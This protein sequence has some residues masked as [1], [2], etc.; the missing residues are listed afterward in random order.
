MQKTNLTRELK[1]D[2]KGIDKF[3]D[4]CVHFKLL[5]PEEFLGY[6]QGSQTLLKSATSEIPVSESDS[7]ALVAIYNATNGPGW[8]RSYNWLTDSVKNWYGVT[9][10][11]GR[12]TRLMMWNNNLQ[13]TLPA[14]ICNLTALN[15]LMIGYESYLTGTIPDSIGNLTELENL[16]FY[17]NGMTGAIPSSI[18][19]LQKLKVLYLVG[20][21]EMGAFSG[22]LPAEIGNLDSLTYLSIGNN[23]LEGVI[24]TEIGQ[25]AKL[26]YLNLNNN[27]L[28]GSIPAEMGQLSQLEYLNLGNNNF[29]G[30]LPTE[31]ST[32]VN[33]KSIYL[34]NNQISGAIPSGLG[35]LDS[36]ENFNVYN[37]LLSGNLPQELGNLKKLRLLSLA[38]NSFSGQ[39]PASYSGLDSLK[40]LYLTYNKFTFSDLDNSGLDYFG[41]D[42]F[43][44][45]QQDTLFGL[46]YDGVSGSLTVNDGKAAENTYQWYRSKNALTGETNDVL[47]DIDTTR[48]YYCTVTNPNYPDLRINSEPFGNLVVDIDGNMY[49]TVTIGEQE[50]LAENLRVKRYQ[51]GT[52]IPEGT[53]LGNSFASQDYYFF[54]DDSASYEKEYGLLYSDYV[55][56]EQ[57][58]VCPSGWKVPS[59]DQWKVMEM[60]LGMTWDVANVWGWVA[61][62]GD[63]E[64]GKLKETGFEH[65]SIPNVGATN[66]TGFTALPAG[67][68]TNTFAGMGEET[69]FMT[70]TPVNTSLKIRIYNFNHGKTYHGSKS[71]GF[72]GSIRCVR[73]QEDQSVPQVT[74]EEVLA[75]AASSATIFATVPDDGGATVVARGIAYGLAS[76][77]VVDIQQGFFFS[78]NG[79]G[80]GEFTA[81]LDDL[82]PDATYYARAYAV[83][84]NGISYG[85]ELSFTTSPDTLPSVSSVNTDSLTQ[86]SVWLY[87]NVGS[88]GQSSV[89]SCGFV[90]SDSNNPTLADNFIEAGSGVGEFSATIYG[91]NPDTQYFIRAYASN[92]QG[93]VYSSQRYIR[94][95]SD[96]P[97]P[98][99]QTIKVDSVFTDEAFVL[100]QVVYDGGLPLLETG[101]KITWEGGSLE[102]PTQNASTEIELLITGLQSSV[103]YTAVAFASNENGRVYGEEIAFRTLFETTEQAFALVDEIYKSLFTLNSGHDDFGQ[104]SANLT[105]DLMGDDMVLNSSRYGWFTKKYQY[106]EHTNKQSLYLEKFWS[107]YYGIISEVNK[108]LDN[109]MWA[110]GP[111]EDMG[112]I[113]GQMHALRAY[114]YFQMV[115][116]F[117]DSYILNPSGEAIPVYI[118]TEQQPGPGAG[119]LERA[120]VDEVY[121]LIRSDLDM[122]AYAIPEYPGHQSLSHINKATAYG[123]HARVALAAGDY[124]MASQY[125]FLAIDLHNGSLFSES[126]YPDYYYE[127]NTSPMEGFNDAESSSEW[128]WGS[129]I[130]DEENTSY[131]SFWGHMDA[132]FLSYAYLGEQKKITQE[133]YDQIPDWDKRKNLWVSPYETHSG[134]GADVSLCQM[135][136]LTRQNGAMYGDYVYMRLAEMYLI[137]A[138]AK[139]QLGDL[140]AA[141]EYL[142]QL[143]LTRDP[144]YYYPVNTQQEM[145][146][147]IWL[148]RRIELWGEGHRFFDIR[149]LQQPLS[150]PTGEN[151]HDPALAQVT[152][153]A[154]NDSLFNWEIPF[155]HELRIV[156]QGNGS[157]TL[158]EQAHVY[159]LLMAEETSFSLEAIPDEGWL[160]VNW[161][162]LEGAEVSTDP[163]FVTSMTSDTLILT[164]NFSENDCPQHFHPVWEGGGTY[165][166]MN[167]YVIGARIEGIDLVPGDQIGVFDG[168][169]CVGYGM[170]SQ[171]IDHENILSIVVSAD[172]G[173][174]NGYT[175]GNSVSYKLWHCDSETEIGEVS[176]MCYDN[177]LS[178]VSCIPFQSGGTV[179]VELGGS[180]YYE[181]TNPLIPGWNIVSIPVEPD[182][183]DLLDVFH[184]LIQQ[185]TLL[186]VQDENGNA[187]ED[188]GIFGDWQNNIGDQQ[189]TEGYKV[190]MNDYD[191]LVTAGYFV[192]YPFAIPLNPGWNMVGFPSISFVDAMEVF[193]QL[194][195]NGSLVKVQDEK[196]NSIENLGIFGGWQNFIGNVW[197]GK[198]YKVKVG[199]PD[200]LWIFQS[201]PKSIASLPEKVRLQYFSPIF[202]GN[203]VD[204]MNFN[205]VGLSEQLLTAGDELAVYD[206]VHCVGAVV[207]TQKML[208]DGFAAL[209]ASASD[210]SGMP[211]FT[212]GNEYQL[213]LWQKA[214]N[215]EL[216][217]E[218]EYIRG[219]E[220]FTQHESVVL[221][222]EKSVLT[223]VGDPVGTTE[224]D[225]NCYP[226]PFSEEVTLEFN[227]SNDSYVSV[228]VLDQL[229]Q[230]VC[231]LVDS[232]KLPAGI[233]RLTWDGRNMQNHKVSSGMYYF[234]IQLGDRFFNKKIVLN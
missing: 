100:G 169:M 10:E 123:M 48:A 147:Q 126:D 127:L 1:S 59:N 148:Q 25:L 122:A 187:M 103:A 129:V 213:R 68:R 91:L 106:L 174:G 176:A 27:G 168:E 140:A 161:T 116:V 33:C 78:S 104:S 227:L 209:A 182:S 130:P 228:V 8:Y 111:S 46:E 16:Y 107:R 24:P 49:T 114:C 138:E 196:G 67:N 96:K 212:A 45:A 31:F 9:V 152:D 119:I 22:A 192:D 206:G 52:L 20:N 172:D 159:P 166:P 151:N 77:P 171:T 153:I 35:Q 53:G 113:E 51:D 194:I 29:S 181:Y 229:G 102:V 101:V 231:I 99:V 32:L 175:P 230:Q 57:C 19:Q 18:G 121:S 12:V 76:N 215:T 145:L 142:N 117:A 197:A 37:N 128:M 36:L 47:N 50:W 74:T 21:S 170:L 105:F 58:E 234:H 155:Y 205:L 217:I 94:T 157:I 173:T 86:T 224:I 189:C 211:G 133:L 54:Y 225:V 134:S 65:W 62:H 226:N 13:G 186:K 150:R 179:F 202:T 39:I 219:S 214:S 233:S 163:H 146:E 139:A 220:Q 79:Q 124:Q 118:N 158:N 40:A 132:R 167:I 162:D 164:A 160:F 2:K 42:A 43:S 200:T 30:N 4:E 180:L 34:Y 23:E 89:T 90:W 188:L 232:S 63:N 95:L 156:T 208:E 137:M 81:E 136:F 5:K 112:E 109:L 149:R 88:E 178:P 210:N 203:G 15:Y 6:S 223:S 41:L 66:E 144:A 221:S 154:A 61:G 80:T 85:E 108:L 125:A 207:L 44:Y 64:G 165:D 199:E 141:S 26:E 11:N 84:A 115:Q 110:S 183:A 60:H 69:Y 191:T 190:K 17:N 218:T 204:H 14:E 73:I 92:T 93:T 135:K 198:G 87:S 222:L 97:T 7:L 120:T 82:Y 143:V 185:N 83:N 201:Y 184:Q 131:A 216:E 98:A 177:Q 28:S 71:Q 75:A 70:S 195:D 55:V 56:L 72:G 38:N 3:N 193:G